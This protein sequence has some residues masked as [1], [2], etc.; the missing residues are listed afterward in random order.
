MIEPVW[1]V[2]GYLFCHFTLNDLRALTSV[3][4]R[5]QGWKAL[6]SPKDL[7]TTTDVFAPLLLHTCTR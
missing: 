5:S 2:E 3:I 1:E 4:G 7:T 6:V